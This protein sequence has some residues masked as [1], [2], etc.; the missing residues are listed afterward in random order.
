MSSRWAAGHFTK[1][2]D[3]NNRRNVIILIETK[4]TD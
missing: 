3:F 1:K 4:Q 2:D